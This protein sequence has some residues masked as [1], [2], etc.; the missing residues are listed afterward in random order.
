[1][2]W[3]G[4]LKEWREVHIRTFIRYEHKS[5][6]GPRSKS[7]PPPH[8]YFECAPLVTWLCP[9]YKFTRFIYLFPVSLWW[10]ANA[11]NV[12]LY[13]PYL[14]YTD[15]PFYI[16]FYSKQSFDF[17]RKK[18]THSGVFVQCL[19]SKRSNSYVWK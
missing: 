8:K 14:Q 16:S 7:N 2:C 6:V 19:I 9:L 3:F 5:E 18:T 13:Y 15:R 1:M 10:R 17:L 12:R 11:R 4:N